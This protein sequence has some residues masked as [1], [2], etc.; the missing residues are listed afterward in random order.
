MIRQ[1]IGL[2]SYKLTFERRFFWH[3]DCSDKYS[4]MY[5]RSFWFS[6]FEGCFLQ[7]GIFGS[8]STYLIIH[9]CELTPLHLF[10][11]T[12]LFPQVKR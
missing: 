9:K 7:C 1:L 10:V 2:D 12:Q 4:A 11:A 6:T 5:R 8:L 3:L